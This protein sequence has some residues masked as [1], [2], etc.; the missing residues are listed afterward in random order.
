MT[1]E[2][3]PVEWPCCDPPPV[4]G[5]QLDLAVEVAS[6][7]LWGRTGRRFGLCTV[8]ETYRV[9][10][11]TGPCGMPYKCGAGN[12]H[13]NGRAGRCCALRLA[14]DPV[15]SVLEVRLAGVTL[16]VEAWAIEA[17][18]LRSRNGCWPVVAECDDPVIAVDYTWG[19]PLRPALV[20]DNVVVRP[21]DPFHAMAAVAVGEVAREVAEAMCGRT[22]KLPGRAVSVIRNGVTV[23]MASTSELAEGGLLGLPNADEFI[24]TV[25]PH[26]LTTRPRV[27]S[28]DMPRVG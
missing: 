22:C 3:W 5:T 14:Q 13:N 18:V 23:N 17:G 27:L 20:V 6:R 25:N 21:A 16:G 24:R 9:P 12:W 19:I 15:Y 28:P 26:R 1:C 10:P 8:T 7:M 2:P 4:T 11:T